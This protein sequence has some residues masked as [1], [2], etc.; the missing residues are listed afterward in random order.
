MLASEQLIVT[1]VTRTAPW[2]EAIERTTEARV[3]TILKLTSDAVCRLI[4]KP[5][6]R[7][8]GSIRMPGRRAIRRRGDSRDPAGSGVG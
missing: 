4:E 3:R 7:G 2:R 5:R 8:A 1:H 6:N